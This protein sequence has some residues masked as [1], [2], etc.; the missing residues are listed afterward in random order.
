[1][2]NK[3][4]AM[5]IFG[6]ILIN[7]ISISALTWGTQKQGE[8]V[9]ISSICPISNC[10]ATNITRISF[11]NSSSAVTN[12]EATHDGVQWNY[13]FCNTDAIGEYKVSGFSSN[14]T[15]EFDEPFIGSFEVTPSGKS[16]S[17]AESTAGFGIIIGALAISFFFMFF[18]FKLSDNQKLFPLTML[19]MLLSF[20]FIIYSLHLS[21][22]YTIDILQ[23][24][25]LEGV[26]S[27]IY[28][29]IL[30]ILVFVAVI[31]TILMLISGIKAMGEAGKRRKYGEG[32]NP[33]TN[34][35]E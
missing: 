24:E 9:D 35:Y 13:S 15:T 1:M 32:F 18:G 28:I 6:M 33:T 8:C 19:F 31:S 29:S 10:N 27:A 23:Y 2:K 30:W 16:F 20:I 17:E 22:V 12:V 25:S 5:F 11:P 4:L 3:I 7:L 21:Y 26:S 14:G 34:T